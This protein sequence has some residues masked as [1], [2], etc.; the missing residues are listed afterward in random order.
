MTV[1][2]RLLLDCEFLRICYRK[3]EML[4]NIEDTSQE[5]MI[6]KEDGNDG[7][8]SIRD[9]SALTG[10]PPHTLRFWEKEMPNILRPQRTSGGQRRYDSEMAERIKTI[11]RLSDEKR[12]SLATIRAYLSAGERLSQSRPSPGNNIHAERAIQLIIDE[13]TDVLKEKLLSLLKVDASEDGEN[14][15]KR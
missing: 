8:M 13:I 4:K 9:V 6:L 5:K 7:F 14:I 15:E 3:T 2:M 10:V 11:K 1:P 12:Y